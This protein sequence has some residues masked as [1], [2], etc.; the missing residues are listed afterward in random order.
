MV[1][2]E[3]HPSAHSTLNIT[4]DKPI[5]IIP[6][7]LSLLEPFIRSHRYCST[8]ENK[9]S[10]RMTVHKRRQTII[11]PWG[12]RHYFTFFSRIYVTRRAQGC[13]FWYRNSRFERGMVL[14]GNTAK[15]VSSAVDALFAKT[16]CTDGMLIIRNIPD[17][18][19]CRQ[20]RICHY[21]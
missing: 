9:A 7:R 17:G 3:R 21:R 11:N 15:P 20:S 19:L 16:I 10:C 14:F 13:I 8:S 1:G 12:K 4:H 6:N 2:A 5:R 18:Y